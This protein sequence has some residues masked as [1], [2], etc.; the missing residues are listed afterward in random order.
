MPG[1]G[2]K[3]GRTLAHGLLLWSSPTKGKQ[4][5]ELT[6]FLSAA[7]W[8][9]S[10]RFDSSPTCPRVL[11]RV[12]SKWFLRL[13]FWSYLLPFLCSSSFTLFRLLL[14]LTLRAFVP[15]DLGCAEFVY[16]LELLWPH[17]DWT[18]WKMA[19]TVSALWKQMANSPHKDEGE[20]SCS[21]ATRH[22][23]SKATRH[24]NLFAQV[25]LPSL[26]GSSS[27]SSCCSAELW[28]QLSL[29]MEAQV[30]S[31]AE[32]ATRERESK[33]AWGST[34][35]PA[36]LATQLWRWLKLGM[37]FIRHNL[38]PSASSG[39]KVELQTTAAA[40]S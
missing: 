1:K 2:E 11:F 9:Y 20:A 18:S 21:K 28:R 38:K 22:R 23:G 40:T 3:K 16:G 5:T 32:S 26:M 4:E 25:S 27:S 37:S 19:A 8:S 30:L 10:I 12:S 15:G 17:C 29:C 31:R 24:G 36:T 33:A 34:S 7:F 35:A 39:V 13:V 6:L 14:S